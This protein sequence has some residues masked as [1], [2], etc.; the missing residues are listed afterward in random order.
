M[1]EPDLHEEPS[2]DPDQRPTA[3]ELLYRLQQ[4]KTAAQFGYFALKNESLPE[5]LQEAVRLSALGV[6]ATQAKY[7]E[8]LGNGQGFLVAAGV[9]WKEGVVGRARV[10]DDL[11]SPA[12]YAFHTKQAVISNHLANE[13][14]FRTPALLVEHGIMRALNVIIRT[15]QKPYGV[16]EVDSPNDGKFDEADVAFME[17]FASIL[18]VA[19]QREERSAKLRE[20]VRHQEVLTQEA[21]HRVKNSLTLVAGLLSMQ[22]R[23]S[24]NDDVSRALRDAGHRVQ[25]VAAVHDKLWRN[26]QIKSIN[27]DAF[28]ADLC[29]QLQASAPGTSVKC[30]GDSVEIGTDQA[31]TIGL[32]VN[33]L[34]T[35]A[36]KYAYDQQGG[37]VDV[38]IKRNG[39]G[40]V[41]LVVEDRGKG[42]P[43]N[44]DPASRESL[45]VRLITSLCNQLET[46]PDWQRTNPGTRF[47][48]D[49]A[50]ASDN[51]DV[52]HPM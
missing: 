35:N 51:T 5:L 43:E 38:A 46:V 23:A 18:G 52:L 37:K 11:E 20:A 8:H 28:V 3:D 34:V 33:E 4:Q 32:L 14:R 39:T 12:G 47:V 10:G 15:E 9:G 45:G 50:P 42:L 17:S 49:F 30:S 25:T 36:I 48:I 44:F 22:A 19:I 31:V 24:G 7:M 1:S 29:E 6:G 41:R 40:S 16:L 13:E 2:P 26:N 21:S 27:L